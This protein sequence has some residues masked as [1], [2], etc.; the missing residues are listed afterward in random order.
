MFG[1]DPLQVDGVSETDSDW[2]SWLVI[3]S[4]ISLVL[5]LQDLPVHLAPQV[6]LPQDL[7]ILDAVTLKHPDLESDARVIK[8]SYEPGSKVVFGDKVSLMRRAFGEQDV[9]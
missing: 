1:P 9:S 7:S 5:I 4:S 6:S 2:R 3:A 8:T